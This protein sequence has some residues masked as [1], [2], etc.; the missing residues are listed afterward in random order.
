MLSIW[1]GLQFY[2][3]VKSGGLLN[4]LFANAFKGTKILLFG[5]IFAL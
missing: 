1:I 2:R 4:W 3:L 5:E